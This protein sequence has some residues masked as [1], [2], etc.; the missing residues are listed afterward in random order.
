QCLPVPQGLDFVQ[1]A[2]IP[3]TFFTVWLAL[4]EQARLKPGEIL[5][6]QGGSSG[7]GTT[8]IQIASAL[9]SRV[10]ATA[11]SAAKCQACV[12]AGAELAIN[13]KEQDFVAEALAHTDGKGVDVVLDMV[14]G[15]YASRHVQLLRDKG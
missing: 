1:A 15:P 6:V 2:A 11:G 9:G 8:T 5:L 10:L 3:E 14:G 12:A 7:I 4:Y 13:Y